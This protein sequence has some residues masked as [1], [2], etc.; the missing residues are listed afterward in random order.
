MP[1]YNKELFLERSIS[2]IQKQSLKNLEILLVND[3]STDNS[4]KILK[5]FSKNDYRIKVINNDRNHGLLYSRAMGILNSTGE[6]LLNL[7]PDDMYSNKFV[8]EI[9]YKKAKKNKTDLIIFKLKKLYI[10]KIEISQLNK[11]IKNLNLNKSSPMEIC[12]Y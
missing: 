6:Y 12:N 4:L 3:C 2:S 8:L 9:L 10:N 11:I 1:I 5:K 7:D